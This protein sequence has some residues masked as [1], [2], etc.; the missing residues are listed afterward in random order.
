MFLKVLERRK[1]HKKH[2]YW[3]L[4]EWFCTA[5]GS[6]RQPIVV[7]KLKSAK[8]GAIVMMA[9]NKRYPKIFVFE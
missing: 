5:K 6:R 9:G 1:G 8:P 2:T 7:H 3:A 4:V